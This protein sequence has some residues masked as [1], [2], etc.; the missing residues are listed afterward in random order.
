MLFFF[1]IE[2]LSLADHRQNIFRE[3]FLQLFRGSRTGYAFEYLHSF[4][5]FP[6]YLANYLLD[7][8]TRVPV[9]QAT[10]RHGKLEVT[11][12]QDALQERTKLIISPLVEV[13]S[14]GFHYP[15]LLL[16]SVDKPDCIVLSVSA[17]RWGFDFPSKIDGE[18]QT[19]CSHLPAD[20]RIFAESYE[21]NQKVRNIRKDTACDSVLIF[22]HGGNPLLKFLL[23]VILSVKQIM[24]VI[25]FFEVL[26][27]SNIKGILNIFSFQAVLGL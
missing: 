12:P 7:Y 2:L 10:D 24:F 3:L 17:G 14:Q 16:K 27:D 13:L 15:F 4:H 6:A 25:S 22:G 11:L 9:K 26:R 23:P 1:F 21:E 5:S 18:N 19:S 8:R 20:N